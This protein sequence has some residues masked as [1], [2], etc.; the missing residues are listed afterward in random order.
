[1]NGFKKFEKFYNV[2]CVEVENSLMR[3]E[4]NG[5]VE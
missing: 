2:K 1:M 3:M 5:E 4:L